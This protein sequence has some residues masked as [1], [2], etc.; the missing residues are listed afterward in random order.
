MGSGRVNGLCGILIALDLSMEV[1]D[2]SVGLVVFPFHWPG[3]L[4]NLSNPHCLVFTS[5]FDCV[6]SFF[7][8]P[9]TCNGKMRLIYINATFANV[10]Y[11]NVTHVQHIIIFFK[12][13][14]FT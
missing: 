8:H 14:I 10:A 13:I 4:G 11:G 5:G 1:W 12:I 3:Y 2:N 7:L 6:F 9:S